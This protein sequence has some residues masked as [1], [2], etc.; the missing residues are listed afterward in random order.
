MRFRDAAHVDLGSFYAR[1]PDLGR[2]YR[3][4]GYAGCVAAVWWAHDIP[5]ISALLVVLLVAWLMAWKREV[6]ALFRSSLIA[7]IAICAVL[8]SADR[9]GMPLQ[10]RRAPPPPLAE[11]P[12]PPRRI[13]IRMHDESAPMPGPVLEEVK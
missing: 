7:A 1:R 10:A 11:Q 6:G 3:I 12:P 13:E 4:A 9:L 5:R 8:I 2:L